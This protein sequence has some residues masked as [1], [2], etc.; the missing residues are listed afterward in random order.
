[1]ETDWDAI[2][3]HVGDIIRYGFYTD[4]YLNDLIVADPNYNPHD[5]AA[6]LAFQQIFAILTNALNSSVEI[7]DAL[8]V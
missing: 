6:G 1:M 8:F 5:P 3:L 2:S 7:S 4:R